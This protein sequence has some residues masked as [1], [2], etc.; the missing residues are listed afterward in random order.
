M[1]HAEV[2]QSALKRG[3]GIDDVVRMW[4][5]SNDE[6]IIDDGEPPRYMRLAFDEVGRPW[7]LVAL[8]FGNGTRYLIIHAMPARKSVIERMQRRR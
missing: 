5:E 1:F 4:N 8:S 2:H 7:E 6:V 3:L